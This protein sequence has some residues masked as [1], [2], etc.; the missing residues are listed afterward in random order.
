VSEH[1]CLHPHLHATGVVAART[2]A[3]MYARLQFQMEAAKS[4]SSPHDK[5]IHQ[6]DIPYRAYP[7]PL[8]YAASRKVAGSRP[9]EMNEFYQFISYNRNKFQKKMQLSVCI[10]RRPGFAFISG[11]TLRDRNCSGRANSRH[12]SLLCARQSLPASGSQHIL[13]TSL[14]TGDCVTRNESLLQSQPY[15]D[16]RFSW[17]RKPQHLRDA[18]SEDRARFVA[19]TRLVSVNG[20][21]WLVLWPSRHCYGDRIMLQRQF[22]H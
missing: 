1:S 22:G 13:L 12:I 4:P 10:Q 14:L 3:R 2:H 19:D 11:A 17:A 20:E 16:G 6:H 5:P 9:Y 18:L 8:H 7:T 21:F 15:S